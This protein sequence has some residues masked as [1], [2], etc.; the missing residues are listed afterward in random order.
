[1]KTEKGIRKKNLKKRRRTR[2]GPFSRFA[3]TRLDER[4]GLMQFHRAYT[5]SW[6]LWE[7]SSEK[8][9]AGMKEDRIVSDDG[10]NTIGRNIRWLRQS[11]AIRQTD[12][13]ARLQLYHVAITRETLVKLEGGRQHI[14]L[15]QLRGLKKVLGV[16][17]EDILDEKRNV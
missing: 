3:L 15:S 11:K 8:R 7:K 2:T 13:V 4:T 14:K 16:S 5:A 1:M 17:Y 6:S 9:G 12:M 10:N